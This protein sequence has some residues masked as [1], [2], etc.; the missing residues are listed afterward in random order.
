V[1]GSG[2][3]QANDLRS[4]SAEVRLAG[5]GDMTIWVVEDLT[6]RI[7]GNGDIRYYGSPSISQTILGS[8]NVTSLGTK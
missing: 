5:S 7:L 1:A 3:V 6:V 4:Q 2:K 8:G